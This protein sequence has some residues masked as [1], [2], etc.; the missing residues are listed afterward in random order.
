MMNPP[1]NPVIAI[2][3]ERLNEIEPILVKDKDR[4]VNEKL[5]EIEVMNPPFPSNYVFCA[6]CTWR[7]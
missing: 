2:S 6:H 3:K 1:Q 5:T 4:I 7:R